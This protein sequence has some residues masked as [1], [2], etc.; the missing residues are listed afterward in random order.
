[1]SKIRTLAPIYLVNGYKAKLKEYPMV[2]VDSTDH[3]E[4]IAA[5]QA[6]L[7]VGGNIFVLNPMLDGLIRTELLINANKKASEL[8]SKV[9]FHTSGTTGAPKLVVHGVKQFKQAVLRQTIGMEIDSDT[10][11]MNTIPPFT[12]GFWFVVMPALFEHNSNM[13]LANQQNIN[14]VAKEDVNIAFLTPN[15]INY[16]ID[17]NIQLPLSKFKMVQSGASKV[18]NSHVTYLKAMK[19]NRFNHMYGSTE[20]TAPILQ[21]KTN[22]PDDM[23]DWLDLSPIGDNTFKFV[24]G[25]LYV[26]GASLCDNHEELGS[27][28]G[29]LPSG[30]LFT[31]KDNMIKFERRLGAE[32][33]FSCGKYSLGV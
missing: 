32:K 33:V 20:A 1:M 21:R 24:D 14:D 9:F 29:Y 17:N 15:V 10:S 2:A 16:L 6:W 27:I 22:L 30:D 31:Q 25:Q 3:L 8:T 28:D 19:L 13:Y 5:Y 23:F 12:S 4:H 7:E 18:L 26:G 11:F